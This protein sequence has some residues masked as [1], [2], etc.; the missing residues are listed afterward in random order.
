M[1][2]TLGEAG[3][4][5]SDHAFEDSGE[6]GDGVFRWRSDGDC[7]GDIGGAVDILPT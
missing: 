5:N 7:A 4:G 6:G 1:R 2:Q 3:F